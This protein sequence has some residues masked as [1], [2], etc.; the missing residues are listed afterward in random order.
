MDHIKILVIKLSGLDPLTVLLPKMN[1]L[2]RKSLQLTSSLHGLCDLH[3]LSTR[4]CRGC[5]LW[6]SSQCF[7]SCLLSMVC[8]IKARHLIDLQGG[9]LGLI[10]WCAIRECKM[11]LMASWYQLEVYH[12]EAAP[13]EVLIMC[14]SFVRIVTKESTTFS[15]ITWHLVPYKYNQERKRA[16]VNSCQKS[17]DSSTV[18]TSTTCACLYQEENP[19]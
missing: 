6:Y 17:W 10:H 5:L 11:C 3:S 15:T 9:W 19:K 16:R 1:G 12:L 8:Y 14:L 7:S 13:S 18:Q 4:L 2:Q